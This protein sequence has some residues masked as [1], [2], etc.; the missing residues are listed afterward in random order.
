MVAKNLKLPSPPKHPAIV[1]GKDII[2]GIFRR[3]KNFVRES[4]K[5]VREPV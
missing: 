5:K 3:Q 1:C 4:D 2:L